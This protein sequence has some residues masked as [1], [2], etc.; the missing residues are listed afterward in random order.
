MK[1]CMMLYSLLLLA[2]PAFAEQS[3]NIIFIFADDLG[4]GDLSCYGAT[5][6]QTPNI[7]KLAAAGRRFTDAHSA[8]AVCTPSRYALLTGEY[9]HRKNLYAPVFL[10]TGLVVDTN[11]Q[12]IASVLKDAGYE[13]AIIGK[14]HLGFGEKT[15][16]WNGE[17][18]P[19]PLELG[20]DYYF[21]VP[22]VNSHPPFV[23]VENHRVV[24]LVPED[25]FIYG[26]R[27]KTAE[28]PE[29][30]H[31]S[32][33][34]GADAAHALY[35]DYQVGT[36]LTE[37]AIEWIKAR[38]KNKFF[39]CLSTTNIHHPFTP[40]P[41]FQGTSECGLYGDFVHELDWIV[42]E[43]V[44]TLEE[45]GVAEN[46]LII[47]TSDNGGMFNHT[48]QEAWTMGHRLNGK[49][50]G[51][52]FDAWEGGHRVPFIAHW[53][54]KIDAGTTSDEL[55]CNVDMIA[56]FAALTGQTLR[57]GQGRDSVNI[58]PALTGALGS[59][60]RDHLLLSPFKKSH[61]SIRKDKWM[62]I[63]GQGGGGFRSRRIGAHSFGGPTAI[64]FSGYENSDIENGKIKKNAPP[65]QLYD[66]EKDPAQT[67]NLYTE[68]PE[69]V[70]RMKA[71]LKTYTP[72]TSTR[73]SKK[74]KDKN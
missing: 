11:Q 29:K 17:L 10:K 66:L 72:A 33:I 68:Y 26:K 7:D 12:T 73:T 62:Y 71:L 52:K 44:K 9:P 64:T 42:G 55:I 18:K 28:I 23:Y 22:V 25:P 54:G 5:K 60:E 61:L 6:L 15:P 51:F 20:F 45:Q 30:M 53:L 35:D 36:T 4:V 3:P 59:V 70:Q 74:K 57:D 46:T 40:H 21:G 24:G 69:V 32:S 27:A 65:A 8:S 14:W 56:T 58:L 47:L 67:T 49:Y 38:G 19:G 31:L 50:L 48:G 43:V 63:G 34:G 16:N 39:L 41:R 13:T 37:R 2:G 1:I